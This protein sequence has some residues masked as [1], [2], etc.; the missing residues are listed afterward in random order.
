MRFPLTR[1]LRSRT[2]ALAAALALLT[3]LLLGAIPATA[4]GGRV[5]FW[6]TVLHNNDAES[7]L[8]GFMTAANEPY[9][10]AARFKTVV[11]QLKDE[12]LT[13]VP[14]SPSADRGVV[15]VSS[16]DNFLAGAEF[17]ASLEKGV[18]FYDAIAMNLIGYDA[19]AI[20]NHEF[21]FGPDVLADF[22]AGVEPSVPFLSANI[23]VSAEPTLDALADAGRITGSTIVETG[24]E[25]V[26]II[27]ATTPQLPNISSPRNVVVNE[28]VPAV[29]AEVEELE[30][31]GV[32]KIILISHL[33]NVNE[34][35]ALAGELTGIDIM[36]AGGGD[37]L[38]ARKNTALAPGDGPPVGD[39]PLEAIDAEG[40]SVP[41][42]T[43]AGDFK[44]V[45]RLV[46][47]FDDEG[48]LLRI[49]KHLSGPVRVVGFGKDGVAPDPEM[50]TQVVQPVAD[51][52]AGLAENVLAQSEVDLNGLRGQVEGETILQPGV[53]NSETN[54]G[55]LT[56]DSML[57]QAQQKAADFGVDAPQ[58]ALQN[59]G[60]I[61][62]NSVI[63]AGDIT[64]LHT[65]QILAFT[66]FV[67]I[68]EDIPAELFKAVLETS[69]SEIGNGRFGQ[70]AGVT[71]TYDP[72][73]Q[74]RVIDAET[75]A[76]S[77]PG[78]RVQDVFVN[79]TQIFDDGAFVGPTGWTV[80]LAT[81]D[82]TFRGGD[83]YDFGGGGFTTV[84]VTYQQAL[85]N[86]L[87]DPSGL[88]GLISAADYP[89]GGEGRIVR[90]P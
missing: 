77:N 86:F 3:T 48:N 51:F 69:V 1:S 7:K 57:W 17:T 81:N 34:D 76:V 83:C 30:G 31:Q 66:N 85:V 53:R 68:K 46:V 41:V 36:V 59:G 56:A 23:D 5:D 71:F 88:N 84:G 72:D 22:I 35:L 25:M 44:Y 55:D 74:P 28:V 65:F 16:G 89:V 2:L 9:A 29:Q 10:G 6:L 64:E 50:L 32:N 20:G 82:F 80:D 15:M 8:I 12:A 63:P 11:D 43:T 79:G 19:I 45:G 38:L 24:G 60:G 33:Q 13:G 87:T 37:E 67:S 40:R 58:V 75:C 62:N 21:D 54:L 42:I 49:S 52:V 26:G 18:P 4:Q 14:P 61:R 47:G 39:Y 27:G 78:A 73:A 70:W 90:L